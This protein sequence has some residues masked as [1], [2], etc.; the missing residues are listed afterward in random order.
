MIR[1]YTTPS[2]SSCR[3]VKKWFMDQNIPFIE[4][5]ILVVQ[6]NDKE[7]MDM[8]TKS[9][10]G[11][12]DIISTRSKIIQ[13]SDIDINSLTLSELCDFI[14]KNPTVLK[15]PIIVDDRK[16]QVGYNAEEISAFIPQARRLALWTCE[17]DCP[18]HPTC[19]YAKAQNQEPR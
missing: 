5:N 18:K 15:R 9:E 3:K 17:N 19:D 2:C 6:L 4:K 8:L 12:D 14:K 16:I 11:T 13:N 10:N 7:L 1:I